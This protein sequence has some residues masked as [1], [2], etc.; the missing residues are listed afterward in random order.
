ML[1]LLLLQT[2]N[3]SCGLRSLSLGRPFLLLPV[4]CGS[5]AAQRIGDFEKF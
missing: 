2:V 3:V 1:K 4:C 5:Q